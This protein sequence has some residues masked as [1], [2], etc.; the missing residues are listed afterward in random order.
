MFTG[1]LA[2]FSTQIQVSCKSYLTWHIQTGNINNSIY[3]MFFRKLLQSKM[4]TST[5]ICGVNTG[6]NT[7]I[8]SKYIYR[9]R[10]LF[11]CHNC[12]VNGDVTKSVPLSSPV[13]KQI[14]WDKMRKSLLW[15]SFAG[16]IMLC[17]KYNDVYSVVANR[18]PVGYFCILLST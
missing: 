13:R 7:P 1:L 9:A 17:T 18:K 5:Y 8:K 11:A 15:L 10:L 3:S 12:E 6:W 4:A 16:I 2:K 14:K